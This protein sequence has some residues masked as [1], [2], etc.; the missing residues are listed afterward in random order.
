[1]EKIGA[2]IVA[3]GESRRMGGVD[4][5]FALLRG[6]PVLA[7]VIDVFQECRAIDQVIVV[8]NHQN[9]SNY[10]QLKEKNGAKLSGPYIGGKRRQDSVAV[11]L[12]QLDGYNWIV[13]HDAVRPL[14]TVDLIERGLEAA[15]ETGGAVAAVPVNDTI[16]MTGINNII[17]T[18]VPRDVFWAAQTPQIF[19]SDIIKQAYLQLETDV[20][21]D[22]TLVEQLGYKVKI[23]FGAY[24]N[25]KITSQDD[26][27]LAEALIRRRE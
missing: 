3:A 14:I 22:A 9:R 25:I 19:R 24:D 5:V 21:D 16:K 17:K 11:G 20:T 8:V 12:S 13:I 15:K 26:L 10:L 23:Y 2:I 27:Y 1:M 7:W 6:K 18:T 4:K